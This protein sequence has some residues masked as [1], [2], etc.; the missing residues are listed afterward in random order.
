MSTEQKLT[1]ELHRKQ[2]EAYARE[3]P[4]YETYKAV[5]RRVLGTA[6]RASFPEA[7]VQ[8]R[9]KGVGS[10]A[11]KMARKFGKYPDAVNQLTDLRGARVIVQTTDQ[12]SG[13]CEF[14]KAN[15]IIAEE[16]NKESL[17]GVDQFGYRDMHFI[18]QLR[19]DRDL[20]ITPKE[21]RVT[22]TRRS[23]AR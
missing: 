12:V 1:P 8:A 15:F 18:V 22:E 13:V 14:I 11:E 5:L 16:E 19:P 21:R 3:L 6:C 9:A 4:A 23:A 2:V 10:F 17:L 7:L 20:G